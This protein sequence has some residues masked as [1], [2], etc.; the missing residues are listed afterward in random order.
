MVELFPPAD[1]PGRARNIGSS[2][3][4]CQT[5]VPSS[6]ASPCVTARTVAQVFTLAGLM[7]EDRF[8]A[9]ALVATFASL[10]GGEM[11][12]LRRCDIDLDGGTASRVCTST[13]C[14]IPG[15]R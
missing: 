9:L 5:R 1:R 4:Y 12:A 14:G 3:G 13:T 11:I 10:R 7:K 15:I 6:R 2:S 8:R